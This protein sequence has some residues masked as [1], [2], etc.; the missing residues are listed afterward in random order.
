MKKQIETER[1]YLIKMPDLSY[2]R[3]ILGYTESDITQIYLNSEPGKTHR[4]RKREYSDKT[5]YIEN[6]KTRLTRVSV[7]EEEREITAPEFESLSL[8]IANGSHPVLKKRLTLPY[9]GYTL[10]VDIYPQWKSTAVLEVELESEDASP[11]FP[12]EIEIIKEV[13]GEKRYSNHSMS[14]DFPEEIV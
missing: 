5:V 6:R 2:L 9:N 3:G 7:I 1:K 8:K 13:T 10:E 12:P 14:F 11:E 4:V